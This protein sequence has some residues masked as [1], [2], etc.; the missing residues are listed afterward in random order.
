M[1]PKHRI[2][3]LTPTY[4]RKDL[5]GRVYQNLID[6]T[7]KDFVWLIIDDGS[8]DGTDTVVAKWQSE[9]T[10]DI[11]YIHKTNEGKHKAL[12]QGFLMADTPYL[13]DFDDDDQYT[14]DCLETYMR[15]WDKIESEGRMDIGSIRALVANEDGS[16]CGNVADSIVGSSS[17][18]SDYIEENF[19][20]NKR[21][22]N[23]TSFKLSAV[24]DADIFRFPEE[25]MSRKLKF[26][27]ECIFWSRLACK[28]KTRYVMKPLRIYNNNSIG[29]TR[30]SGGN[31]YAPKWTSTCYS[32][33]VFMNEMD[34]Y[35]KTHLV[36]AI[37]SLVLTSTYSIGARLPYI[38]VMS[39]INSLIFRLVAYL[40]YPVGWILNN[41]LKFVKKKTF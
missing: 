26:V 20:K 32:N 12:R 21:F 33:I 7:Y 1:Q 34:D 18:D 15:E 2:T 25:W 9:N 5:L 39:E 6:Q 28:Y 11:K 29:I 31:G 16:I 37:K 13:V 27:S 10:I 24:R 17:Y 23:I 41:Y 40:L 3:V 19:N 8:I 36:N 14:P 4:N 38:K 22:E 30:T 35:Y